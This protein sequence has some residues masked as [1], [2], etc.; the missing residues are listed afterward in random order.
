MPIIY[1]MTAS[2]KSCQT[3]PLVSERIKD[4]Q[5]LEDSQIFYDLYAAT[6]E[7]IFTHRS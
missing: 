2:Q 7:N 3:T 5:I 6:S 4:V 1:M